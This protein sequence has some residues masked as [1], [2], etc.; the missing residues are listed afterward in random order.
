MSKFF[1]GSVVIVTNTLRVGGAA[2]SLTN[3]I[4][5]FNQIGII[6]LVITYDNSN[7]FDYNGEKYFWKSAS[8]VYNSENVNYMDRV[9]KRMKWILFVRKTI[10]QH[11]PRIVM[12]FVSDIVSDTFFALIGFSIYRIASERG[13]PE[14]MSPFRK[15]LYFKILKSYNK[16]VFISTNA[17]EIY[18]KK[19]DLN[20]LAVLSGLRNYEFSKTFNNDGFRLV[21]MSKLIKSKNNDFIIKSFAMVN[22]I[23]S[24][25]RLTIIGDGIEKER[26]IEL[27]RAYGVSDKVIFKGML[28]YP[29]EELKMHSIFLYASSYEGMPNSIMEAVANSLPVVSTRF[30]YGLE[31]LVVNSFNGYITKNEELEFSKAII[32]IILDTDK[33]EKFAKNSF[34]IAKSLK[35][36]NTQ[37]LWNKILLDELN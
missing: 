35:V 23:I 1:D 2:K 31:E 16:V 11:K 27:A 15:W 34:R 36:E 18:N 4:S 20:S 22:K 19:Y 26:L 25:S 9:L 37:K 12:S 33:R 29:I 5:G 32:S 24:L 17:S 8:L 14:Q 7:P 6:P 30:N 28:S 3:I 13:N 10:I 21:T